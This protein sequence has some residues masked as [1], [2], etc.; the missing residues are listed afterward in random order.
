VESEEE[1]K[2][3][4]K[5]EPLSVRR[6]GNGAKAIKEERRKKKEK[7]AFRTGEHMRINYRI[8]VPIVNFHPTPGDKDL[9]VS[10]SQILRIG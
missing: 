9:F 6:K 2:R 5:D 4:Q 1:D 8:V 7:S 3:N 10:H